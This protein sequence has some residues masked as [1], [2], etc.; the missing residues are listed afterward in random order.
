VPE[1]RSDPQGRT[2]TFPFAIVEPTGVAK[3]TVP[4]VQ[5]A[6]GPGFGSLDQVETMLD[7]APVA[8][9]IV[10]LDYRG[11]GR[12]DPSL[13]C[14]E[15][16]ALDLEWLGAPLGDATMQQRQFDALAACRARL[17]SAGVDLDAYNYEEIAADLDALREALGYEQWD[18]WG[19]SNGGRVALETVRRH[20]E[21]VRALVLD[22]PSPPQGN[23]V[24]DLW[25]HAQ[26]AFDALFDACTADAR[27]AAAVP[28][29]R[30]TWQ[31]L[32]DRLAQSPPEVVV[33][34]EAG[35]PDVTVLFA[36]DRAIEVLRSAL[37]DS[38]LIPLLPY[39]INELANGRAFDVV[40]Q[41]IVERASSTTFS[42]GMALS[43]NCREEV[44]FLPADFPDE[45]RAEYPAL[46][47][48]IGAERWQDECRIWDVAAAD[49]TID[50][51]VE[52]DVPALIFSGEFDPIH[53]PSD[54]HRIADEGL[55]HAT[56]VEVPGL[57]HGVLLRDPC[58]DGVMAAFLADPS[59]PVDASCVADMPEPDWLVA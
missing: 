37:Y 34:G 31:S 26:R 53:P 44:P 38:S 11:V 50:S 18:L 1:D 51:P 20:P 29:L 6:G 3:G 57:G 59:A 4:I 15:N 47:P 55:S 8:R 28:D 25:P 40:A 56:V 19:L 9:T 41:L 36:P 39:Y 5:L 43:V 27:C 23:L 54:A 42:D 17:V 45:Q 13:A 32:V 12:A 30:A 14:P 24:G 21:G 22:A 2:I 48:G 35:A 46:A 52:S 10:L 33:P 49:H 7:A 58:P 16:D